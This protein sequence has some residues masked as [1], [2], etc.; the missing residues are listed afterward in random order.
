MTKRLMSLDGGGVRGYAELMILE[1]IMKRVQDRLCLQDTP[2][3]ADY[4][5]MIG[6]TSTGG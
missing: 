3:P 4:F 1:A 6:G 2:L 5:D